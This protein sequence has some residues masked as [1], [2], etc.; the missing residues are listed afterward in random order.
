V[1]LENPL[2]R[3]HL[4]K[5]LRHL[6]EEG[7]ILLLFS[8]SLSGPV[9]IGGA[10]GRQQFDV[11]IHRLESEY[12]VEARLEPFPSPALA[13]SRNPRMRSMTVLVNAESRA[14]VS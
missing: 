1:R 11:L 6:A 12:G 13:G 5:G 9:P 4:D 8:E 10:V 14:E 3:K 7:T 2:R